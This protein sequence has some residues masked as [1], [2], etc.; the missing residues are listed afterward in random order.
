MKP[1][2]SPSDAEKIAELLAEC[3]AFEAAPA[4]LA[5]VIDIKTRKV[6]A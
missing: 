1:V 4:D 5:P 3:E 2:W 6:I